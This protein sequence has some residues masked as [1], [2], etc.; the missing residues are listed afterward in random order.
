MKKIFT[1]ALQDSVSIANE[2]GKKVSL[3]E[4]AR[5][6]LYNTIT[7]WAQEK[8]RDCSPYGQKTINDHPNKVIGKAW[9]NSPELRKQVLL[10]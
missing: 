3:L 5:V 7:N 2:K 4:Q 10:F 9:E 1:E 6:D 8:R